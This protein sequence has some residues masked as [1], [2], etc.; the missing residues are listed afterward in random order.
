MCIPEKKLQVM[1]CY[2]EKFMEV[3]TELYRGWAL[4]LSNDANDSKKQKNKFWMVPAL[5]CEKNYI[6]DGLKLP[7]D[8]KSIEAQRRTSRETKVEFWAA[9]EKSRAVYK[10]QQKARVVT[11][12]NI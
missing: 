9:P 8:K 2:K 3:R 7:K 12:R 1:K 6:K 11:L 4:E 5:F 10:T